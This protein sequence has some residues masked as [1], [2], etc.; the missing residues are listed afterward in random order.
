MLFSVQVIH[1][2]EGILDHNHAFCKSNFVAVLIAGVLAPFFGILN[3]FIGIRVN[4]VICMFS[5]AGLSVFM[6]NFEIYSDV[7]KFWYLISI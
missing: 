2:S 1:A 3:D 6:A 5:M 4:S 7:T